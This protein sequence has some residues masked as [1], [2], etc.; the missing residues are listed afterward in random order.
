MTIT[1]SLLVFSSQ[2]VEC[3]SSYHSTIN[4]SFVSFSLAKSEQNSNPSDLLELMIPV[5]LVFWSFVII[6]FYCNHGEMMT[7]QFNDFNEQV[8]QCNWY[9]LPMEIQKMLLILLSAT[10]QPVLIRGYGSIVCTRDSFKNVSIHR[11]KFQI[12]KSIQKS[13]FIHLFYRILYQTV[14][15]GFSYFMTLQQISRTNL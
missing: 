15:G 2:L 9:F 6:Y 7:T 14:H 3:M 13:R 1:C 11:K 12:A 4:L 8:C 5:I 10:G